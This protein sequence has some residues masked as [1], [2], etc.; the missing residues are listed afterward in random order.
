MRSVL[1]L[2]ERLE[3]GIGVSA[4]RMGWR[5]LDAASLGSAT[6][7]EAIA[8]AQALQ[9]AIALE[10]VRIRFDEDGTRL[11]FVDLQGS[12]DL[13]RTLLAASSNQALENVQM[14]LRSRDIGRAED[15]F[16]A[17]GV[18]TETGDHF[19]TETNPSKLRSPANH[20]LD[21]VLNSQQQAIVRAPIDQHLLVNA[22]A[23]TGKTHT[24]A[25]RIAYLVEYEG[26]SP[27]S[28]LTLTFTRAASASIKSRLQ[29]HAAQDRSQVDFVPVSTFHSLALRIIRLATNMRSTWL[30]KN[31]QL[32]DPDG[33]ATSSAREIKPSKL[34]MD[35]RAA[36][37]DD[38]N[39]GIEPD[40]RPDVYA[41]VLDRLRDGTAEFGVH[42][43]PETLPRG[44]FPLRFH[45]GAF[46]VPFDAIKTVWARYQTIM[47]EHNLV[48][49]A[50][51]MAEAVRIL[52]TY[53]GVRSLMASSL[54]VIVVDEFQDT[55]R[56]QLRLLKALA[57]EGVRLNAAGDADQT[58]M[59]FVGAALENMLDFHHV[60]HS[61]GG[62]PCV[63]LPLE[64]NYRSTPNIVGLANSVI[65]RNSSRLERTL[66][67]TSFA[68]PSE[69]HPIVRVRAESPNVDG[70]P[71][72]AETI[73]RL[74]AAGTR[75]DSIAVLYRKETERFPQ[76]TQIQSALSKADIGTGGDGV[77][78][79]TIHSV[80]GLEFDYVFVFFLD[81]NQ[82]PDQRADIEE[83][84]R[85]LYVAI[86]R[87]RR[88]LW[89]IG[90]PTG[91]H[92]DFFTETD[93]QTV[94]QKLEQRSAI[95][96]TL[97]ARRPDLM[98]EMELAMTG[99]PFDDE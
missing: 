76:K 32:L 73:S 23:G 85:L 69:A 8:L 89:I 60:F 99:D 29:A 24:L 51:A 6:G 41:A 39:D 70:A 1:D 75:Q 17:L 19:A 35:S 21:S 84:R 55:S 36:I 33:R 50:G 93:D 47:A 3:R 5:L 77:Y 10:A 28:I 71:Y 40:H 31:F 38:L 79:G 18:V 15:F 65:Q 45:L 66:V 86:T 30:Q 52:E 81:R 25:H 34:L 37:F 14:E 58:I 43:G 56:A 97:A 80:K 49:F 54:R 42:L 90:R 59:S 87:A 48:D 27:E 12:I 63:V 91:A 83:E 4:P 78:L 11:A 62:N 46:D 13:L 82:L 20:P 26:L 61:M 74:L 2:L 92:P 72:I 68:E 16:E 57:S 67:P 22:G 9:A 53:Q 98:A 64:T 94:G 88:G 44:S 95:A 96:S 7:D